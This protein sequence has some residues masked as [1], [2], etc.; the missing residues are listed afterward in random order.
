MAPGRRDVEFPTVDGLTLR[1]WFY[2]ASGDGKHPCII[3]ANGLAGL[4]E[5]FCPNFA[6]R[7]QAAGYGVLLFDHRNWGASD[8]LPRNETNPIQ[9]ARDYSDAFD[10]VA[11]LDEVDS[12]RIVYWGTSMCGGSVLHAAAFDNRIQAV[13]SQVP[14][15]SGELLSTHLAPIIVSLY[16]SRQQVK[17]GKPTPLIKLFAETPEES[18]QPDSNALLHDENLCDFIKALDKD[19]LPWTPNVTPQTLLDVL[20]FEPLAFM[21]RIAPTPLLL[22]CAE[23]DMCAPTFTQLKAH[24]LAYEPKKLAILKGAGHFDPYHG[25]VFEENVK[26]QLVFLKEVM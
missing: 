6:Q 1:G 25:K 5:Q 19:K 17:T 21:H 16:S 15:V 23:N 8:G 4:K 13:I 7:F 24:A 14:F 22:V 20:A 12:S 10:Y 18:L 26:E 9:T 2:T 3:M 11:S